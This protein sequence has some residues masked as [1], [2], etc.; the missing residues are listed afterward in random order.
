MQPDTDHLASFD[1]DAALNGILALLVADLE[2]RGP[3]DPRRTARIL[4]DAGLRDDQIGAV[5]GRDPSG[6]RALLDA[7]AE[8]PPVGRELSVIDRAR[9]SLIERSRH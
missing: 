3:R 9:M 4:A 5:T 6:V 8:L 7:A 1:A 2:R